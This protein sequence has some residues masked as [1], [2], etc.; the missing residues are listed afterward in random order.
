MSRSAQEMVDAIITA[1]KMRGADGRGKDGLDGYM[2]TMACTNSR[3]F[4]ILLGW[5]LRLKMKAPR[6]TDDEKPDYLTDEEARAEFREVGG[7]PER[8]FDYL[9]P[10]DLRTV[11][12]DRRKRAQPNGKRAITEAV[13]N[14][15]IRHGS[16]G[17]GKDGL[18]GYFVMLD[19]VDPQLLAMFLGI[20]QRW[21]VK[22]PP[23]S[24]KP[25]LDP[26]MQDYYSA[27]LKRCLEERWGPNTD[28]IGENPYEDPEAMQ[29]QDPD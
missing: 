2:L 15:A 6:G 19:P 25:E 8:F 21:Q 1:G 7:I 4:G 17:R 10:I 12:A 28:D 24:P 20:A 23:R 11:P 14:A 22:H 3:R 13:I 27:M 5:A 16:D 9:S 18:V 26:L 29:G